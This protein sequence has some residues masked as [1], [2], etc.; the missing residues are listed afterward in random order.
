M[1]KTKIKNKF[2]PNP[3]I[4]T[5]KPKIWQ[6]F[7][8]TTENVY[9][10]NQ[11]IKILTNFDLNKLKLRTSFDLTLKFWHLTEILTKFLH[12]NWKFWPE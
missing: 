3:R 10:N 6:F 4:L 11:I 5:L 2:W 8:P 1:L 9:L 12:K 7:Y